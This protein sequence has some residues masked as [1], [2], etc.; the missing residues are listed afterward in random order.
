[1][2]LYIIIE[3]ILFCICCGK[4]SLYNFV[5]C[6]LDAIYCPLKRNL[7]CTSLAQ[8]SELRE[9]RRRKLRRNP[10]LTVCDSQHKY[11]NLFNSFFI[12][13]FW[14]VDHIFCLLSFFLCCWCQMKK[15][16]KRLKM[17]IEFL[18]NS[19]KK[20]TSFFKLF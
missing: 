15:K 14:M 19:Y 6:T 8:R 11:N 3:F 9:K 13:S 7:Q 2:K 12:S 10:H 5:D 17:F 18:M 16:R 4:E 20:I 1:M